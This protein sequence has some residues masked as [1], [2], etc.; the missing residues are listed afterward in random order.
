MATHAGRGVSLLSSAQITLTGHD[1]D[2]ERRV[3]DLGHKVP[4]GG[5][6]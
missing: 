5:Q 6:R 1:K 4:L 3:V 2:E